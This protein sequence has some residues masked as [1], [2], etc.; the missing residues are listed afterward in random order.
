MR[1]ERPASEGALAILGIHERY[2]QSGG[3]DA[4]FDQ[5]MTLLRERGHAVNTYVVENEAHIPDR[6]GGLERVRLATGAVWSSRSHRT[7]AR[8]VQRHR[9]DIVHVHNTFPLLSPS[10]YSACGRQGVP[11]V[12]TLHNYRLICPKAT[13]F[14]D[15]HACQDCV[16][17]TVPAPGVVHACYRDSRP[18]TAVVAGMLAFNSVRGTWRRD[19]DAYIVLTR[20]ARDLFTHGGL[21]ADRLHV[22]PNF[23]APD[24]GSSGGVGDGFVFVGRMA[25]EKGPLIAIAAWADAPEEA[26]LTLVGGGPLLDEVRTAAEAR[27]H[28]D[29]I[30]GADRAEVLDRMKASRAVIVPSIWYEG[31]PLTILEAFACGRPVI[32][33]RMGAMAELVRDGTT[34][35]TFEPGDAAGLAEAVRWATEHPEEMQRMGQAARTEFERSFTADR[36]YEQLVGLYR[37]VIAAR[38]R[39]ASAV[40]SAGTLGG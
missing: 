20:F 4:V 27:P 12:Q 10:I 5:E 24:P 13:L 21:P 28:V 34:G 15:G 8:L 7:I 11:V 33:S 35:L 22:K 32:A 39:T 25:V 9:P 26:R 6:L 40:G 14:R 37:E 17:R 29:V 2:K 19:V 31:H 16:G 36:N 18:Q 3:E 30:G 1:D 38:G 23:I